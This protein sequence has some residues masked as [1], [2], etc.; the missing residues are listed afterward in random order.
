MV[1]HAACVDLGAKAELALL[2]THLRGI[3]VAG[4]HRSHRDAILPHYPAGLRLALT[5]R[6]LDTATAVRQVL[7]GEARRVAIEEGRGADSWAQANLD[8]AATH[9]KLKQCR[10]HLAWSDGAI[11]D[12]ARQTADLCSSAVR[13][14]APERAYKALEPIAAHHQIAMPE[15][16][17]GRTVAG[18]VARLCDPKWWRR[19]I[20]STYARRSEEVE[21]EIGLVCQ[22]KGLY[23]SDDSVDRRRQQKVRN[24]DMLESMFAVNDLGECFSVAQ[25]SDVNTS[26]PKIRRAELMTRIA[27]FERYAKARDH[28]AQFI[29]VTLPSSFHCV[30]HQSGASN[31]H[32][33]LSTVR[34]G[35]QYL[36]RQWARLRSHLKRHGLD[37]YGF[38][39]A[40]PH[41]D[42]TP[43]WHMLLF[44]EAAS[45]APVIDAFKRYFNPE[46]DPG[47]H[48][49][50]V[51]AIDPTKG[52]AAGYIAKYV[53]K[54]IDGFAV[55]KD[56]EA[57]GA[58]DD[59]TG[60]TGDMT[61]DATGA[62]GNTTGD[63]TRAA[64][65][66]NETAKRVDAWASTSGIRQFQQ[67]GG[68]PVTVWREVRRLRSSRTG[69]IEAA[70]LAAEDQEWDRFCEVMGGMACPAGDRPV[71]LHTGRSKKPGQ[72]GE[73]IERQIKGVKSGAL[74][75]PTRVR[76]WTFVRTSE[77]GSPWT[78]VNNCTQPPR[79][80]RVSNQLDAGLTTGRTQQVRFDTRGKEGV[81][82]S[83]PA[84]EDAGGSEV[85]NAWS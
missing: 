79:G 69:A 55:G 72:Y 25:L 53:S 12:M 30:L 29:T 51:K 75:V 33:D 8:L 61:R 42:G 4:Y 70:R 58:T 46:G 67:I 57:T 84:C 39:I 85:P 63:A 50:D 77:S 21:R 11:R 66:A 2:A 60:A 41:H 7:K 32:F 38:R 80:A 52:S 78:R 3:D 20:R 71:Q 26:N 31:P 44:M 24:R 35:H 83:A 82:N 45:V 19:A 49:L 56:Y 18:C 5:K 54:N 59:G 13:N 76:S 37:I 74:I 6:Y 17:R 64:N 48:R 27:G 43:H 1:A 65:D 81:S 10:V 36:C 22:Q 62:T 16:T 47:D 15:P 9:L 40:E 23:A 34:E 28:S 73:A 14:M 68:P